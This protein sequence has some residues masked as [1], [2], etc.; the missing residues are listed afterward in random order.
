M[1]STV[2]VSTEC[3]VPCLVLGC[4]NNAGGD[5]VTNKLGNVRCWGQTRDESCS[6]SSQSEH[7]TPSGWPS[8]VSACCEVGTQSSLEEG[9]GSHLA[10]TGTGIALELGTADARAWSLRQILGGG[11]KSSGLT[12]NPSSLVSRLHLQLPAKGRVIPSGLLPPRSAAWLADSVSSSAPTPHSWLPR[13]PLAARRFL[14]L[15]PLPA[16]AVCLAEFCPCPAQNSGQSATLRMC[17][18]TVLSGAQRKFCVN[19]RNGSKQTALTSTT[20]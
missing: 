11:G 1:S 6:G 8:M 12:P 14:L 7:E 18:G 15:P 9:P 16:P 20:V 2:K 3:P 10:T 5:D 13:P 19:R 17:L 4:F